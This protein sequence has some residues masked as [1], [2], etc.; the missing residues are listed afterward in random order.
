MYGMIIKINAKPGKGE[1]LASLMVRG[2]QRMPGC[3]HYIVSQEL[4]N[5][6]S[7]WITELWESKERHDHSLSMHLVKDQIDAARPLILGFEN[8]VATRPIGGHGIE[9]T[10]KE[11]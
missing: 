10:H 3:S 1:E 9:L 2:A 6:D 11:K 5:P 7:L 4:N 8:H